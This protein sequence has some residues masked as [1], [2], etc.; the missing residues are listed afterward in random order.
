M[1]TA[2]TKALSLL[3]LLFFVSLVHATDPCL[4][5]SIYQFGDSIADTGNLIRNGPTGASTPAPQ[6][7]PQR[8]HHATVFFSNGV[9]FA[10]A[11]STALNSSFFTSRNLHVPATNTPLSTQLSWFKSHLRST[12]HSPSCLKQSLIMMGE[13][14]GNDYNYGFF[15]GKSTEEIRSYIPHVVG[16]IAAAAREVIRAGAVNVVVPGNFP[17]GCFP[18]YLTSFPVNDPKAYDDKG[19]LIR[20]NEFA[21][22]HNNQLQEAISSL[23]KEFPGVVIVYGDYYNAFQYVLRGSVGFDKS[24]ALKSCCGVGGGYNYDGMRQC[25]AVGVPVCQNPD[26]F[27]SWDGVHLTQKAYRFMSKFLNYKILPQLKCGGA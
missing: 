3:V 7:I 14:G 26:K 16:A 15:Q 18:I 13:I 25:G 17:I 10:V 11:G 6:P 8:K 2:T 24:V 4:I 27:I 19:C 22:D 20:L 21:V 9:N 1:S 5:N 12:C 23:Q